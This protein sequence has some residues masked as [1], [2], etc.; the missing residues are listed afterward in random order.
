M[1]AQQPEQGAPLTLNLDSNF[2]MTLSSL[3]RSAQSMEMRR[4]YAAAAFKI[5][6]NIAKLNADKTQYEEMLRILGQEKPAVVQLTP[7][8]FGKLEKKMFDELTLLCGKVNEFREIVTKDYLTSRQ[9]F[10]T[11]GEVQKNVCF[12]FPFKYFAILLVFLLVVAN[13][14]FV[15]NRFFA[16]LAAGELKK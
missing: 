16:A 14:I 11:T 5:Q 9:F 4:Q 7:E 1:T 3:I 15:G 8:Q 2:M 6:E 12:Y 10:T 13:V